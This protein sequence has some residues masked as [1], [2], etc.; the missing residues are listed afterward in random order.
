MKTVT[1]MSSGN[2]IRIKHF[3]NKFQV[4]VAF[5]K[6]FHDKAVISPHPVPEKPVD[7]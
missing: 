7:E 3:L 2:N 4:V 5:F 6:N 1:K